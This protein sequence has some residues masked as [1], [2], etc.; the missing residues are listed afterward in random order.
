MDLHPTANRASR[1]LQ[2]LP[3][4]AYLPTGFGR[5]EGIF[6]HQT[7]QKERTTLANV[8][9]IQGYLSQAIKTSPIPSG[10]GLS[11][12]MEHTLFSSMIL[13]AIN[14]T[15]LMPN[16]GSFLAAF[17]DT[18]AVKKCGNQ[19]ERNGF[20]WASDL[21]VEFLLTKIGYPQVIW[22]FTQITMFQVKQKPVSSGLV[23]FSHWNMAIVW[24]PRSFAMFKCENDDKPLWRW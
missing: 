14:L 22:W 16:S 18:V 6:R 12:S 5:G 10:T 2:H 17:E 23:S 4:I 1:R 20:C 11:Q 15:I 7:S 13:P 9:T 24:Y 19:P 8:S 21:D 3:W